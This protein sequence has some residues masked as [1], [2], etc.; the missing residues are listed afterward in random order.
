MCET[1]SKIQEFD[2]KKLELQISDL[3]TKYYSEKRRRQQTG[4]IV[5]QGK[6]SAKFVPAQLQKNLYSGGGF[7]VY[8]HKDK[9]IS[10]SRTE[11]SEGAAQ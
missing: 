11:K 7:R 8:A 5:R 1:D 9:G 6:S 2:I 3:K 4:E 10:S